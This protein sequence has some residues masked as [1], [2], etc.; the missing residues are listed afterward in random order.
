MTKRKL[1]VWR[2]RGFC[3]V[4]C[5]NQQFCRHH[6]TASF[7]VKWRNDGSQT[8]FS[9]VYNP[10]M[11][12]RGCCALSSFNQHFLKSSVKLKW[13]KQ[14]SLEN[15]GAFVPTFWYFVSSSSCY[16]LLCIKRRVRVRETE[17]KR[18][19]LLPS[20]EYA[21]IHYRKWSDLRSENYMIA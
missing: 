18:G 14:N 15:D 19:L 13:R 20:H 8:Y 3:V 21:L 7:R 4:F 10:L 6:R 12:L 5:E 11:S 9:V 2:C 16:L 1:M 17:R